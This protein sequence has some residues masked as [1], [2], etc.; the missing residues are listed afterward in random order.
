MKIF[1]KPKFWSMRADKPMRMIWSVLVSAA[2]AYIFSWVLP[3]GELANVVSVLL[4]VILAVA[5]DL[6]DRCTE[7][8][9]Q[10]RE[11]LSKFPPDEL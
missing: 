1:S 9:H 5:M 6:R 3:E 8:Y 10:N 4:F 2:A 11:I 7:I